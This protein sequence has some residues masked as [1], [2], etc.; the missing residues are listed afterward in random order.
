VSHHLI[1]VDHRD[2]LDAFSFNWPELRYEHLEAV[3]S[4][5]QEDGKAPATI[6]RHLHAARGV[7]KECWRLGLISSEDYR[8]ATDIEP[9][10]G[11]RL[12]A[13]RSLLQRELRALFETCAEAWPETGARNAAILALL[14]A[15]SL[16]RSEVVAL[17]LED[18]NSEGA[19]RV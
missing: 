10:R 5:L 2:T 14:Y 3:R 4:K 11:T 16:R 17:N 13:G 7:L 19:V 12:P 9:V 18:W 6:N 15:G 8:R 1:E